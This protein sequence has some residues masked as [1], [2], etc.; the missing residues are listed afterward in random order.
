MSLT[1]HGRAS[2]SNVQAVMWCIAELGLDV[3]R[4]DVGGRYGG[5]DTPDF[6]AMNPMGLVPVLQD[7]EVTLFESGAILRY[8]CSRYGAASGLE[9]GPQADAWAE[10]AKHTLC[11]AFTVPIFWAC[12]R[13]PEAERDMD[14]VIGALR[15]Y[16]QFATIAMARRGKQRF[17]LG[18]S[19]SLADI[20]AGHVLY[21]YFTLDLPRQAPA[22]L[23]EYYDDLRAN[24]N[25]A[26]HVMVDYSELKARGAS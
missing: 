13:T 14:A 3:D 4:R 2:S 8:L 9:H 25:Y 19:L 26:Q 23:R 10:W 17:V 20:W 11:R 7:G 5:N 21:R 12:Y 1:V 15:V 16:E 18:Q 22:G 6:L 24:P